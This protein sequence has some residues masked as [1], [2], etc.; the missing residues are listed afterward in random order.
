MNTSKGAI[1]NG[2]C[3]CLSYTSQRHDGSNAG[4]C[5]HGA[6]EDVLRAVRRSQPMWSCRGKPAV[7]PLTGNELRLLKLSVDEEKDAYV[8]EHF[9]PKW[10]GRLASTAN[11]T[12]IL[13]WTGGALLFC[14]VAFIISAGLVCYFISQGYMGQQHYAIIPITLVS[15]YSL[16]TMLDIHASPVC[17]QAL[18]I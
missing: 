13:M 12:F 1:G 4:S 17:C 2:C 6:A 8:Y 7:D 5:L 18:Y 10:L 16:S 3:K 14:V 9:G 15:T 11:P